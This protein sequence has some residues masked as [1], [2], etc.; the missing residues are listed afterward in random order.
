MFSRSICLVCTFACVAAA[1]GARELDSPLVAETAWEAVREGDLLF[2]LRPRYTW[3]DQAGQPDEARWGSV[4]TLLGWKTLEYR[5]FSAVVEGINV[6][7]FSESGA[8][9][10]TSTP[11]YVGYPGY[12]GYG[13]WGAGYYPL[14]EDPDITNFNRLYLDYLGVPHTLIRAGRQLLAIDNQRFIGD[15]EFGQLPQ[16][17]IGALVENTSLP[18]S[19]VT[20]GYFSR[21]RNAYAVQWHTQTT[22]VNA[23]YEPFRELKLA[24]YGYFQN[25]PQTGSVT[26][27]AD[28]SNQILGGRLWG[29]WRIGGGFDLLYSAEL[30]EQRDFAGGSPLIDAPYRRLGAGAAYAGAT[31]RVDYERLGSNGSAYGFQTPLGSTAMFTGRVNMF[32][33]TPAY[34]L[35]DRRANLLLER[36]AGRLRVEYHD[37]SSDFADWDLGYEWDFGLEWS[38]TRRLSARADYGDYR[39][40]D[41]R[42]GLPDT[43]K[44]WLTVDF[45]Y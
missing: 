4:R 32:S 45:R 35:I 9:P 2:E 11:G 13:T 33:T 29:A 18:Q 34:G 43:R 7:R 38:F 25:Q 14:I 3:V 39:A 23:R 24:G 42:A 22:V 19:R 6:A 27:L 15:Y 40:G 17:F 28:N 1:A 41:P 37:F 31:L 21:V 26:G 36:W 16:S 20:L 5:G 44:L 12:A 10:Y 8:I 30:A